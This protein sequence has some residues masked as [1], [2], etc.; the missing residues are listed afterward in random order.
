MW[1]H[2]SQFGINKGEIN[3]QCFNTV[4]VKF[5]IFPVKRISKLKHKWII[6]RVF[7]RGRMLMKPKCPKNAPDTSA[8]VPFTTWETENQKF[9]N[10]S[11]SK[12]LHLHFSNHSFPSANVKF[13]ADNEEFS[14]FLEVENTQYRTRNRSRNFLASFS[15]NLLI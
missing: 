1:D 12:I 6:S 10:I 8:L 15:D 5:K 7:G 3:L 11:P 4:I 2:N 13:K 9:C 14:Y